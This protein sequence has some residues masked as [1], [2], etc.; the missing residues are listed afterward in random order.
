MRFRE[1]QFPR[2]TG[3]F[4][5]RQRRGTRSTIVA[6]DEH[7]IGLG[8]ADASGDSANAH[9]G[10]KLDVHPSERVGILE[11]V[12][13]LFEVFDGIDVVMR[14]R[15]DQ[16][17]AWRAVTGLRDPWVY[18]V[19]RE[20]SAFAGLGALGHFDLQIIGVDQIFAGDPEAAAGN[21][22]DAAAPPRVDETVGIFAAFAGVAL[23]SDGV[24]R[25][26]Q[27]FM[28]LGADA[29]VAHCAGGKALEDLGNRLDFID[30]NRR[31][32]SSELE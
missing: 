24:H 25:D 4:Q 14:R 29:A 28:G 13:Q 7:H 20:L 27:G 22:F 31:S 15:A 11:V 2:A 30:G 12:N 10:D 3:V 1:T 18:L 8:F 19:T 6:A 23:R 26:G 5:R 16:A 9:L 21:L 17:N 32:S